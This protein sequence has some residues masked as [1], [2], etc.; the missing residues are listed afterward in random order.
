MAPHGVRVRRAVHRRDELISGPI[1]MTGSMAER[2]RWRERLCW[3]RDEVV[4]T[5]ESTNPAVVARAFIYLFGLGALLVL[6]APA[7]P[8]AQLEHPVPAESAVGLAL[9]V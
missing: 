3:R 9:A 2:P 7:L 8:A 6:F 1:G 4:A 5:L